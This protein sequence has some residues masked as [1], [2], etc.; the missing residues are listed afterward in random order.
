MRKKN[1]TKFTV[2]FNKVKQQWQLT[3]DKTNEVI[4]RTDTKED[5]TKGG[6]LKKAIGKEGGSVKIKKLNNKFQEE[7]TYPDSADPRKTRG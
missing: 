7:R 6:I 5:M 3:N 2:D 4:K 1:L